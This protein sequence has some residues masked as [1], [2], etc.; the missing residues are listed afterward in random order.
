MDKTLVYLGIAT[1]IGYAFLGVVRPSVA[2]GGLEATFDM[3][4]Q[5]IPWI[6]VSMFAAGLVSQLIHPATVARLFGPQTGLWGI[7]L[8]A[9]LGLLGTG[10]R[11]AVYPLAAGLLAANATPGAVFAFMTSWQLVSL[12]RLPAEIPFLGFRFTVVRTIVSVF[13]AMIGGIVFN[14]IWQRDSSGT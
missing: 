4:A 1:C 3:F 10:S 12:P 5:A 6:I 9:G 11:W 8:A 13:I 14:L 7:F 2:S